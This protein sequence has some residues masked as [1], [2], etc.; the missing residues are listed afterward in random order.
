MIDPETATAIMVG[1]L[2]IFG[3]IIPVCGV[4]PKVREVISLRWMIIVV[5]LACTIGVIVDFSSLDDST[6]SC[7]II[8]TAILSGAFIVL[9]SIEKGLYH[10]W[11]GGGRVEASVEKGDIKA[12]IHYAPESKEE[13]NQHN[14][15]ENEEG[16]HCKSDCEQ[17]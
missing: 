6:R 1:F 9:R 7:V 8:G 4:I 17:Q 5:F 3:I 10:G 13:V 16:S 11:I 14:P 2:I 15:E 12:K